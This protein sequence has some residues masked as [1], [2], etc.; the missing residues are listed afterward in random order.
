M[1][2]PKP[3]H[4]PAIEQKAK[5]H[6]EVYPMGSYRDLERPQ[7]H[8]AGLLK[9]VPEF[10]K[11]FLQRLAVSHSLN[12]DNLRLVSQSLKLIEK[13]HLE[14]ALGNHMAPSYSSDRI[15]DDV[16]KLLDGKT[17]DELR[18]IDFA[19][20]AEMAE[21]DGFISRIPQSE[22]GGTWVHYY[23]H[24]ANAVYSMFIFLRANIIEKIGKMGN[25]G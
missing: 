12:R 13:E 5:A 24:S 8:R 6:A 10:R 23:I 17:A 1:R 16:Q 7:K 14:T 22:S 2:I 21:L 25:Q 11:A 15:L 9:I 4:Y 19:I 20:N 3:L 18:K